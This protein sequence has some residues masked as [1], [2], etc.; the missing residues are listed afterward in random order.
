MVTTAGVRQALRSQLLDRKGQ[1][2]ISDGALI[3]RVVF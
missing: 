2:P 3:L 1:S